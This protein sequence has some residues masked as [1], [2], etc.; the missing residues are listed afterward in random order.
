MHLLIGF[1]DFIIANDF[2]S[3]MIFKNT[4]QNLYTFFLD[5]VVI[6]HSFKQA[7]IISNLNG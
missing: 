2:L 7:L 6:Q 5:W 4:L 1:V 3:V